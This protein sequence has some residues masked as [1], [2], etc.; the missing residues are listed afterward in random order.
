MREDLL[1]QAWMARQKSELCFPGGAP[2][3]YKRPRNRPG[4]LP[5]ARQTYRLFG[6]QNL[7]SVPE[8]LQRFMGMLLE[9]HLFQTF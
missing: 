1:G 2:T 3:P 8:L 7:N 4:D 6:A 9:N 5:F